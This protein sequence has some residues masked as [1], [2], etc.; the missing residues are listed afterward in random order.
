MV[1]RGIAAA[2]TLLFM[3]VV[4]PD[5]NPSIVGVAF[6]TILFY[7]TTRM[8][9]DHIKRSNQK[10]ERKRMILMNE[11]ARREN[12][13]RLDDCIFNPFKNVKSEVS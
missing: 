6:S 7:E 10:Q 2:V 12:G 3:L 5:P 11:R 8:C 13:E 9:L 1:N 4:R